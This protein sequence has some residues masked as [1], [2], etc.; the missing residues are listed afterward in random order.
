MAPIEIKFPILMFQLKCM[1]KFV[2]KIKTQGNS[3]LECA[4]EDRDRNNYVD[5][6]LQRVHSSSIQLKEAEV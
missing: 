2:Y 6:I 3:P 1:E 5:R 4:I